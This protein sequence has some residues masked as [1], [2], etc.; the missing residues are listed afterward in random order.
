M[1]TFVPFQLSS[2]HDR[3]F[4]LGIMVLQAVTSWPG[5]PIVVHVSVITVTRA[6]LWLR[7]ILEA[8]YLRLNSDNENL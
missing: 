2:T 3:E 1:I 7:A 8:S 6:Q 5:D 4:F